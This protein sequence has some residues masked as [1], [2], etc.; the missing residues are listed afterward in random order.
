MTAER[1]EQLGF[2]DDFMFC[3]IL[4][5]NEDICKELVELILDEKIRRI[6]YLSR[7]Q[8]IE[9]TSDGKG[10]GIRLRTGAGKIRN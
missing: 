9:I 10:I 7:Q 6:D 5:H 8:A 1:Y 2:T 3:K 4:E